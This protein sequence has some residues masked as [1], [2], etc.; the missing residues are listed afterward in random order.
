MTELITCRI[1]PAIPGSSQFF[2][3][4]VSIKKKIFKKK[5]PIGGGHLFR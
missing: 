5:M 1:F 3:Y 4:M 2:T